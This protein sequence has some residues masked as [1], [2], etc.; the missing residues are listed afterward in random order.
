MWL[1]LLVRLR[2]DAAFLPNVVALAD[3]IVF[4]TVLQELSVDVHKVV[5]TCL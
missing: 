3:A 1:F 5:F 2:S 4:H